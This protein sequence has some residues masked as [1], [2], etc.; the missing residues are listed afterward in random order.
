MRV[1]EY[2]FGSTTSKLEMLK[3]SIEKLVNQFGTFKGIAR[4]LIC[5]PSTPYG[6]IVCAFK[7][8]KKSH[9][10]ASMSI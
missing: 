3:R 4:H 6:L 5:N 8:V 10:N 2:R 7:E 9:H 1:K